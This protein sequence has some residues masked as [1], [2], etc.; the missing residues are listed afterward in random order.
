MSETA[1]NPLFIHLRVHTAYSLLEGACPIKPL[2]KKAAA[3]EMPALGIADSDNLFGSLEFSSEVSGAGIQPIIGTLLHFRSDAGGEERKGNA[4]AA[5]KGEQLLLIAKD[6]AGYQNLMDLAS[7]AYTAPADGVAPLLDYAQLQGR[8]E[9]VICLTAGRY[10]GIGQRLLAGQEDA[11]VALLT[12]LKALFP[13]HLY[14]ELMRHDLPAE[15][16]LEPKFLEFAK[17]HGLPIV[18]TNDVYFFDEA[19]FGAHD[20]LMCIA[21]GRY[22]SESDRVRLNANFRFKSMS[23]MAAL[24]R[25]Q[26]K[27]R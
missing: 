11:A 23:E 16:Q 3:A 17:T 24:C 25:K 27:T 20:A 18:G 19:M 12:Q 22:L 4:S 5:L 13:E 8:T 21:A 9:G 26:W 7:L 1:A 15:R 14:I 10:G 6:D 2:V